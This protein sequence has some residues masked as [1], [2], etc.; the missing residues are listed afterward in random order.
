MTPQKIISYLLRLRLITPA[1]II[2]GDVRVEAISRRNRSFKIMSRRGPCYLIKQGVDRRGAATIAHEASIYRLLHDCQGIGRFLVRYYTYDPDEQILVLELLRDSCDLRNYHTRVGRFPQTIAARIGEALGALH[3]VKPRAERQLH[4]VLA[5][6]L[7]WA[8]SI[9]RPNMAIMP[10][11][12]AANMHLIEIIQQHSELCHMLDMLRQSWCAESLIHQD[13]KWDNI[14]ILGRLVGKETLN[15][16]VIDWEFAGLGDPCW[17]IGTVFSKYLS[18]WLLS[19]PI[20]GTEPLERFI[21][22]ARYR[23]E[24]MQPAMRAYWKSYV[25][26]MGLDATSAECR[27]LRAICYGAVDLIQTGFEHM[28]ASP[29]LTSNIVGLI[30]LSLN[31]LQRP[32]A[33]ITHLLGLTRSATRG[34]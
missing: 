9:H 34:L 16:R 15:L 8:L 25:S 4:A 27:L 26:C 23:L 30:Q 17:D 6:P 21:E 13:M 11:I 3:Q 14:I 24:D 32:H 19:I 28:Q 29:S 2:A 22:L 10:D 33:A 12:S 20:T 18:F 31:I 1:A 5:R 7:P